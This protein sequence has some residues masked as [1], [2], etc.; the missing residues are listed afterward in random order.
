MTKATPLDGYSEAIPFAELLEI[1]RA[2]ITQ[3]NAHSRPEVYQCALQ[4]V[5]QKLCPCAAS[6]EQIVNA[7]VDEFLHERGC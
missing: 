2:R 7:V 4:V 6:E 5:R 1:A 3:C